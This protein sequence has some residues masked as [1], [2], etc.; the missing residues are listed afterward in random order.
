MALLDNLIEQRVGMVP[1]DAP[2]PA[3]RPAPAPTPAPAAPAEPTFMER[4]NK[5]FKNPDNVAK[6]I[7]ALEPM[8]PSFSRGGAAATWAGDQLKVSQAQGLAAKKA[9]MT[10]NALRKKAESEKDEAYKARLIA[11]ADAVEQDPTLAPEAAKVL[12]D[13]TKETFG[14]TPIPI[15]T[16]NGVIYTQIGNQGTRR[17][18]PLQPG[19]S[20]A[21]PIKVVDTPTEKLIYAN[22]QLVERIPLDIVSAAAQKAR[23]T[24]EGTQAGQDITGI[25][26]ARDTAERASELIRSLLGPAINVDG[27]VTYAGTKG[28]QESTGKYYG[29]LEPGTAKGYLLSQAAQDTIPIIQQLQGQTF[30]EAFESLK[31]GGQITEVE[32]RKAEAAIARLQRTQS[33]PAFIKALLELEDIILSAQKRMDARVSA[34]GGGTDIQSQAD[35]ILAAGK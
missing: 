12:F 23:G 22:G 13:V 25:E 1:Y 30:L 8:K 19:E 2:R 5:F 21:P 16:P 32:G 31:G 20:V 18:L 29:T 3:A 35:A 33:T 26:N 15:K 4:V 34:Q 6:F 27:Q 17:D 24:I 10:I 11:A 28:L 7:M 14:V 9:T